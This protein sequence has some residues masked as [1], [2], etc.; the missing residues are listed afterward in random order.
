M[1]KRNIALSVIL[2][3]ITCGIY[4]LYWIAKI[5]DETNELAN[6]DKQTSGV[7][8]ILLTIITCSIYGIYWAYKMGQL[9]DV[10]LEKRSMPTNNRAFVYLILY[11]LQFGFIGAILM[12][13]TINSMIPDQ[14]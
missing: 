4:Y 7:V 6:P 11:L 13:S 8:V 1:K 14:G 3:F 2:S 12:Q 10:A 9:Q 5:N